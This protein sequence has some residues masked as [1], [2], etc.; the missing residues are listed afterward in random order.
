MWNYNTA[1][2]KQFFEVPP[3]NKIV[4]FASGSLGTGFSQNLLFGYLKELTRARKNISVLV[5]CGKNALLK[6]KI[7]DEHIPNVIAVPFTAKARDLYAAADV[8]LTKPGGLTIAEALQ[9]NAKILITHT[10]P[11]QE[12]PNYEY[13]LERKLVHAGPAQLT[14]GNLV[15]AT[16]EL[17]DGGAVNSETSK[18]HEFRTAITQQGQEGAAVLGAIKNLFH[19][20]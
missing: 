14:A 1:E 10:L 9:A 6:S 2:V 15:T 16:L 20:V 19:I 17:L 18:T 3:E 8:F 12:E 7:E 13:L 4:L 11:G 5:L